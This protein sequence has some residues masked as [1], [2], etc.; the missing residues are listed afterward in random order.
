MIVFKFPR[1]CFCF[2]K[3]TT[4]KLF[5]KWEFFYPVKYV[6]KIDNKHSQHFPVTYYYFFKKGASLNFLKIYLFFALRT[7]ELF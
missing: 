6:Q 7:V 1:Y 3:T 2:N 5:R 4:S